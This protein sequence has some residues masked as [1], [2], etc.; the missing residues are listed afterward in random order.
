MAKIDINKYQIKYTDQFFFDTNVWLLIFGTIANFQKQDQTAYSKFLQN[1]I[2]KDKPIFITSMVL[3]EFANVLLRHDFKQWQTSNQLVNQSFKKDFIGTT[4]YN[5]SVT[6][7]KRI[8]NNIL[9][10]PNINKVSDSFHV[11]DI[12]NIL[13]DFGTV[14]YNDSYLYHLAKINNYKIVTNDNDFH[15]F[16]KNID[17]ITNQI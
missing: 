17:I 12:E 3:S 4:D 1:L 11:S 10:I 2:S 6:A 9:N 5:N 16:S 8:V 13:K 15:F 7:I 14:D